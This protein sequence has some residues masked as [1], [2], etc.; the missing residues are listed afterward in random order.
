MS[1]FSY[2]Y[3]FAQV[4]CLK[5]CI[6]FLLSAKTTQSSLYLFEYLLLH[7]FLLILSEDRIPDDFCL[8]N[9]MLNPLKTPV[10]WP[11][12]CIHSRTEFFLI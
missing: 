6:V 1:T 10:R 8:L 7:I 5:L 12:N 11:L 3:I 2:K 4:I 9:K